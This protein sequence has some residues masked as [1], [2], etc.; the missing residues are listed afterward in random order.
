MWYKYAASRPYKEIELLRNK[1]YGTQSRTL[2]GQPILSSIILEMESA[3]PMRI[4]SGTRISMREVETV[5][6]SAV[7]KEGGGQ[8]GG[9]ET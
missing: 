6:G 9:P 5:L 2:T 1:A 8:R 4:V 7:L 3:L